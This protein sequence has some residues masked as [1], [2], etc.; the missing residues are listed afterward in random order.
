M[1][2]WEGR[3]TE[4]EVRVTDEASSAV[5][6]RHSAIGGSAKGNRL[7]SQSFHTELWIVAAVITTDNVTILLKLSAM[8]CTVGERTSTNLNQ[9]RN[10]S[11]TLTTSGSSLE[12]TAASIVLQRPNRRTT[13]DKA[14]LGECKHLEAMSKRQRCK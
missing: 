2:E 10:C 12:A 9:L 5:G 3:R 4:A 7:I 1:G 11:S 8:W 13:P 14:C 6:V